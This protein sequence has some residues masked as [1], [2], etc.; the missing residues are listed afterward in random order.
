MNKLDH[1]TTEMNR[2]QPVIA[3]N[4]NVSKLPDQ[5]E[6]TPES[7]FGLFNSGVDAISYLGDDVI[8]R[9]QN[10]IKEEK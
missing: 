9:L 5:T 2:N 4:D 3:E 6:S 7:P 1:D 8:L 10:I